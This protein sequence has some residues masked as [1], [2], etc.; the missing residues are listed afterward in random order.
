MKK[1]IKTYNR[2]LSVVVALILLLV[3]FGT[4]NPIYVSPSN[5]VDIINQATIYGMMGL[6][7]TFIIIS[8]GIDLSVGSAFALV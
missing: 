1:I 2:E 3:I 5:L 6:G 8:G 4:I 7:M